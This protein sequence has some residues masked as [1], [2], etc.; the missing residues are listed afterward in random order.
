MGL[1]KRLRRIT[2]ARIEA[3][4]DSVET[5]ELVLPRLVAELGEKVQE[6]ANAEAK[7]MGA[8]KG[9]Q[10]KL[11][12]ATGRATRLQRGAKQA[13][14]A[15][16][17]ETARRGIAAQIEA[18]RDVERCR[19]ALERAERAYREASEVRKQLQWELGDLQKRKKEILSRARE[20]RLKTES[21]QG[22]AGPI[23]DGRSILDEVARM[24]AALD[25]REAEVR[26]R[27]EINSEL[28][29]PARDE[30]LRRARRDE[31][32]ES[33]LDDIRRELEKGQ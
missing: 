12:E 22:A 32:V 30:T 29:P 3:F 11:D 10:R 19:L 5:P 1:L 13:V 20:A 17:E 2:K 9:A 16:D 8:T 28:R 27:E 14:D 18:E 25:D 7:S 15:G 4:L 6:A 23:Q 26:V 24:E 21:L 31:E 33:R